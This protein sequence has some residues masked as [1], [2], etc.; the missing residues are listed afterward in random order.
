M[1]EAVEWEQLTERVAELETALAELREE[2]A[3]AKNRDIPLLKGTLRRVV[4]AEG[5]SIDELPDGGRALRRQL[6]A[7]EARLEVIED[8]LER[9]DDVG[10]ESTSK[11]EKFAAV[12]AFAENNRFTPL[13]GTTSSPP[14]PL[15]RTP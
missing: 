11:E 3:V 10:T 9:L 1:S 4:G 13:A 8:R 7:S 6:E 5:D 15:T 2:V 14:F 12:L